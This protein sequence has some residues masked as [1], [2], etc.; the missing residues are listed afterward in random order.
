MDW[1]CQK[2]I[3][4][5]VDVEETTHHVKLLHLSARHILWL[6]LETHVSFCSN[7]SSNQ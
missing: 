1:L 7:Q 4:E 6:D 2:L 5:A 3:V